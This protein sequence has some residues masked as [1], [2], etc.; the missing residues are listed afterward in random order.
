MGVNVEE[1]ERRSG[2]KLSRVIFHFFLC[3]FPPSW[4]RSPRLILSRFLPSSSFSLLFVGRIIKWR[5]RP[6]KKRSLQRK[7]M[8]YRI[9]GETRVSWRARLFVFILFSFL[10]ILFF[11]RKH[12]NKKETKQLLTH[13][14]NKKRTKEKNRE[15]PKRK[16]TIEL[17]PGKN[18]RH[19]LFPPLE[20]NHRERAR[21]TSHARTTKAS[22]SLMNVET[23][24]TDA[25]PFLS[26]HSITDLSFICLLFLK[27]EI[28]FTKGLY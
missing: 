15:E 24:A 5:Q 19:S 8:A 16:E 13:N 3:V 11:E 10:C 2:G 27:L 25:R 28:K 18:N 14:N 7:E 6:N 26:L 22:P 1:K 17:W 9:G 4:S 12:W 23:A 20:L 21:F